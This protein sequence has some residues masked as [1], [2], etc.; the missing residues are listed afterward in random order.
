MDVKLL[1]LID[2]YDKFDNLLNWFVGTIWK[3]RKKKY[4]NEIFVNERWQ[5]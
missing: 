5:I 1:P 3:M 4:K 2:K